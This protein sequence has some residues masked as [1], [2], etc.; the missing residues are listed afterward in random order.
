M[1]LN[2][3]VGEAGVLFPSSS[4]CCTYALNPTSYVKQIGMESTVKSLFLLKNL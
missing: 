1:R 3:Q 2:Q 4:W